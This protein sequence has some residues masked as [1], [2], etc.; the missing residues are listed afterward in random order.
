[1]FYRLPLLSIST[2]SCLARIS[3]KYG[4]NSFIKNYLCYGQYHR[5]TDYP[6]SSLVNYLR[7][8][9]YFKTE[10]I[11]YLT[12]S[13]VSLYSDQSVNLCRILEPVTLLIITAV[14]R[15]DMVIAGECQI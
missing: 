12:Q 11:I 14:Y 6:S 1:V 2:A 15:M 9:N 8:V 3:R 5:D 10:M 13:A 4:F 7:Y